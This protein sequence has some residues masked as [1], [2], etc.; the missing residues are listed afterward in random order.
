M[1]RVLPS[2]DFCRIS[3]PRNSRD[4]LT[5]ILK[6]EDRKAVASQSAKG[7]VRRWFNERRIDDWMH[8]LT[9]DE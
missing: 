8:D 2:G 5:E 3:A 6:R 1:M 7:I 9:I 4:E